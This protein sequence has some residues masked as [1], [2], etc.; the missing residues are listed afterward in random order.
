VG[1]QVRADADVN[2][3]YAASFAAGE[4]RAER[5]VARVGVDKRLVVVVLPVV[6]EKLVQDLMLLALIAKLAN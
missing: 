6:D 4:P 2:L 5:L 3:S 1:R